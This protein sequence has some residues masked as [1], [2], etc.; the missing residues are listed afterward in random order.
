MK[1]RKEVKKALL[2]NDL[3]VTSIANKTNYSERM[4]YY[5]I[6]EKRNNKEIE[7]VIEEMLGVKHERVD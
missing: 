1:Y 7:K 5:V 2:D 6:N 4:V 3:T